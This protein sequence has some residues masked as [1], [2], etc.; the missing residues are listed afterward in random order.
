[1]VFMA[2][3]S[4]RGLIPASMIIFLNLGSKKATTGFPIGCTS[5]PIGSPSSPTGPPSSPTRSPDLVQD[6]TDLLYEII[7]HRMTK[8]IKSKLYGTN[9]VID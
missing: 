8:K 2:W 6:V 5:S 9:F 1:M 3:R 4:S 7:I